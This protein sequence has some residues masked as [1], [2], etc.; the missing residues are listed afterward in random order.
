MR[1][2]YGVAES[3]RV[4][5]GILATTSYF[6]SPATEFQKLIPYRLSLHDFDSSATEG[7]GGRRFRNRKN[8]R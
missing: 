7:K 6:T 8:A 5:A 2:L 4:T 1:T 3:E